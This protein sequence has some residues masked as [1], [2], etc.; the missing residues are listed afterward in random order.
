LGHG[1]PNLLSLPRL[2]LTFRDKSKFYRVGLL[3]PRPTPQ[4]GGPGYPLLSGSSP[5][6]CPALETLLRNQ[7]DHYCIHN[8]PP[9]VLILSRMVPTHPPTIFPNIHFN[10]FFHLRLGLPSRF[11]Y[12]GFPTNI[13]YAFPMS[14]KR[15]TCPAHLIIF[16]VIVLI[17][18]LKSNNYETP[19]YV[20]S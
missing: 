11:L 3:A 8:S 1:L 9:S 4:P 15:A 2:Q 12:Y 6:T 5:L 14:S 20:T 17:H 18:L 13:L 19:Y 7:N 16:Y 10:I